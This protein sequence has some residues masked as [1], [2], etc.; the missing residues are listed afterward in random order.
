MNHAPS[1]HRTNRH[2]FGFCARAS[3]LTTVLLCAGMTL[4][5]AEQAALGQALAQGVRP[6]IV[7]ATIDGL[8][9][10]PT[11]DYIAHALKHAEDAGAQCLL[12]RMNTPGGQAE[13]MRGIAQLF[14]NAR[15]PVVVYV[16]PDG[17]QAASAG[18]IVALAANILAMAPATNIGAAHPVLMTGGDIPGDM[19]AKMV[20]DMAAFSRALAD[21]RHKSAKIAE[22]FV[23]NSISLSASEAVT[24]HIADL[25]AP[26]QAALLQAINGRRVDTAAGQVTLRT[27]GAAEEVE[28]PSWIQSLLMILLNPNVA[29]IL[30]AVALYGIIAEIQ[31][32]GAIV[33]GVAG[34]IALILSLYAMSVLSVNAAGLALILLAFFLFGLDLY[35]PTHGVLTVGGIASFIVGALMIF[36]DAQTGVQVSL[37]V[38]ISL[39][40]V[41]ALFF[42][43]VLAALVR[44]RR[45]PPG[46]GPETLIGQTGIARTNLDP[47]GMVFCDGAFWRAVNA[48]AEPVRSGDT[49]RVVGRDGLTLRV[50]RAEA[51]EP[52]PVYAQ[53]ELPQQ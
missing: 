2:R 11:R 45:R 29:L 21:R 43:T 7:G 34:S 50:E 37:V 17:A 48:G 6:L 44:A 16:A 31:H 15:V 39:A 22:Q 24:Q 4:C 18:A 9:M 20:N 42:G 47:H 33:P 30:G 49:V 53:Q 38:V 52:E 36:N 14:L 32:P 35:A 27:T 26:S 51:L 12:V 40:L 28:E 25:I 5:P 19:K 23:R 3:G 1:V 41:T 13:A 10:P 8:I 46:S